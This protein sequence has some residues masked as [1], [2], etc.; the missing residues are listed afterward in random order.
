MRITVS[1]KSGIEGVGITKETY[2]LSQ[3]ITFTSHK[4]D[5]ISIV[6]FCPIFAF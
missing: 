2:N 6:L 4:P 5:K 1:W 3:I